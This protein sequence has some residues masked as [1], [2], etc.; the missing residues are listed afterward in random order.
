MYNGGRADLGTAAYRIK[1]KPMIKENHTGNSLDFHRHSPFI[2]TSCCL[3]NSH[4]GRI[5]ARPNLW[6]DF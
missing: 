1:L 5:C 3:R 2:S 4:H 6:D